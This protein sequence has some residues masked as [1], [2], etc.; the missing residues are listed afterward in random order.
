MAKKSTKNKQVPK[1]FTANKRSTFE[2][3]TTYF[4]NSSFPIKVS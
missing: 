2:V 3:L 1:K 4:T